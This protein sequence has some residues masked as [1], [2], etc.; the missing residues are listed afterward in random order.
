LRWLR[1][2][3][4]GT[5]HANAAEAL[6]AALHRLKSKQVEDPREW[7]QAT[8]R[9]IVEAAMS[10]GARAIRWPVAFTRFHQ[11]HRVDC[12]DVVAFAGIARAARYDL[13]TPDWPS[14]TRFSTRDTHS[15]V[16]SCSI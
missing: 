13:P 8:D 1:S 10:G 3:S 2:R 6:S 5:Q 12:A 4:P 11:C 9:S 14:I 15:P 16:A 7:D